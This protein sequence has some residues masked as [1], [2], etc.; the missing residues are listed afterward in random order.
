LKKLAHPALLHIAEV[1]GA[2]IGFVVAL[3][4][5]NVGAR[6]CK[7]RL[8]PFGWLRF[9]RAMKHVKLIRVITLG[10]VPEY[11]RMGIE[12]LLMHEV[13]RKGLDAG[14]RACEASWILEDN[15][16]ML[17]P[18]ETIGHRVWRRYRIYEKALR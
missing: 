2:P 11:R 7:G 17:G 5:V 1:G 14:F 6:A 8:W 13:I 3:P 12:T 16:D 4:D 10:V 15:R 9:L 18:L